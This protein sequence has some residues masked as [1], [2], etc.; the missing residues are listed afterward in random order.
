[1][2]ISWDPKEIRDVDAVNYWNR[3]KAAYPND[4]CMLQKAWRGICAVGRDNARTPVQWDS[5]SNAGFTKAKTPW[6]RV[7]ENY[8]HGIN[9]AA[10]AKDSESLLNF[11]KAVLKVRKANKDLFVYGDFELHN[12]ENLQ[13]FTFVKRADTGQQ[14]MVVL[15]FSDRSAQMTVP[16]SMLGKRFEML[17]CNTRDPKEQ[18]GPWEGRVYK[19]V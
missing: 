14:A 8:H 16:R 12:S 17:L 2:P 10:Q 19:E 4:E 9:V 18:L 15:N 13:T 6:M 3:M 7:N 11:W 1:M 5:S